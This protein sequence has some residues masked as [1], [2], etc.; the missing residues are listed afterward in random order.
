MIDKPNA[1]Q[2][3]EYRIV[4]IEPSSMLI[5]STSATFPR[6]PRVSIPADV[7]IADAI[8]EFLEEN[9]RLHTIQLAILPGEGEA[10]YC[11][12]H[13]IL[14][15][16]SIGLES[17]SLRAL[18][19]IAFADLTELDRI[20]ILRI[21]KGEAV[22]LGRFARLG[23]I[24]ELFEK[25]GIRRGRTCPPFPRHVNQGINFCLLS[26]ASDD[27]R[28]LWFKAVGEPNTREYFLTLALAKLL[29]S[30]LPKIVRV[31]PEWTAWVMD[32]VR[33]TPLSASNDL[34]ACEQALSALAIMQQE[35][36]DD[37]GSLSAIGAKDW[38]CARIAS[39][40]EPF[41]QEA[42]CA[43]EAQTSTKS[44]P[45]S[46][47][48]IDQLKRDIGW[49]LHEFENSGLP[50]TLLHGDIGHGNIITT[51]G[52]PVFLDWAETCV[53][54]P[55]LS[56]EHLL[57]DLAKSN[58]FFERK[59]AALR[60]H[61]AS[62]WSKYVSPSNLATVIAFG[63]AIAA[64]AYAIFIWEANR[65]THGARE[66]WPILRSLLR[67]TKREADSALEIIR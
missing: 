13:E 46:S 26:M 28:D 47:G 50:K 42:H 63:P 21:M 32:E 23:W 3:I 57:A 2:G 29:P 65:N 55:F 9:Y 35:T 10:S 5:L 1:Q 43:M 4:A 25:A 16:D 54:H 22:E 18:G 31:H 64:F 58:P 17:I 20:H 38:T 11:A 61:Y 24:D 60:H 8:T 19:E 41:F 49:A 15:S 51:S 59:Q 14:R 44:K 66:A 39:L 45:L 53:G 12:I 56:A 27:G 33:G 6:L 37:I 52:G 62:R 48:A 36:V 7:R 34:R 30:Y 67:R 40:S